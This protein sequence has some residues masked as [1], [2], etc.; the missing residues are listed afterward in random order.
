MS[1]G[2]YPA[3]ALVEVNGIVCKVMAEQLTTVSKLRFG[4]CLGGIPKADMTAV[5]RVIGV[6]LGF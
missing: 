3:E 1:P 5:I 2:F 6:Q 4:E